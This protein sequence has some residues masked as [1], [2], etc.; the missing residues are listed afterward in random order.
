MSSK[1]SLPCVWVTLNHKSCLKTYS[2]SS[3]VNEPSLISRAMMN[4][5]MILTI[6]TSPG[7]AVYAKVEASQ[8]DIQRGKGQRQVHSSNNPICVDFTL[9]AKKLP[10]FFFFWLTVITLSVTTECKHRCR[11]QSPRPG[12]RWVT[13]MPTCVNEGW[14]RVHSGEN[15]LSFDV[16][17]LNRSIIAISRR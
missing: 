5:R 9:G 6:I 3:S 11:A 7:A 4:T 13:V 16:I 14:V 2:K 17:G 1:V 8:K 10:F 15:G 12:R